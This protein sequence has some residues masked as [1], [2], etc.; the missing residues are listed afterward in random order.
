MFFIKVFRKIL[1][2]RFNRIDQKAL[3]ELLGDKGLSIVDL[4]AAGG[5][6]PR[7]SKI[8]NYLEYYGFE[9]DAR[10]IQEKPKNKFK[11]Y[12]VIPN[13][14]SNKSMESELHI[15]RE[16]GKSSIYQPNLE[17]LSKFPSSSRFEIV[18]SLKLRTSTLD[19]TIN[20]EIDFI[21]LDIQ[22]GEL[23]ALKGAEKLLGNVLG[24][25]TEAEFI[26]LYKSQPLFGDVNNFLSINNFEFIDF[27]NLRRWERN[28]LGDY[29][30]CVFGDALYLKNPE[31]IFD[32]KISE[33]RFRKYLA[34]LYLYNRF[35]LI[36][37][38]L[39][40]HTKFRS[41][42]SK[43]EKILRKKNSR[44]QAISKV[45]NLTNKLVSFFGVEF[46]THFIY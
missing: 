26:D 32:E 35:D 30:Q 4:G 28:R 36:N 37:R 15:S 42:L 2:N 17:F 3:G 5:V 9:P 1:R 40:L 18:D 16:E 23:N 24:I 39:E 33:I 11:T 25:E 21:K 7:W 34:I 29:G 8:S 14:I 38:S 20:T 45:N 27:T 6:E 43:F 46:K 41:N 12:N 19:E 44:F 13:L 22:G 10:T 31:N